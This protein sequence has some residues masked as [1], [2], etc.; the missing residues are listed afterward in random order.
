MDGSSNIDT[1]ITCEERRKV[2]VFRQHD[3]RLQ[4]GLH[5]IGKST[6][7]TLVYLGTVN[8]VGLSSPFQ[9]GC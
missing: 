5:T 2:F 1:K 9:R 3:Y 8:P 6:N 7:N 4:T